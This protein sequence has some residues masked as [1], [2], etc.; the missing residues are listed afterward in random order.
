ML[1]W[2]LHLSLYRPDLLNKM[3]W[4]TGLGDTWK[5][6]THLMQT[7]TESGFKPT[8][9]FLSNDKQVERHFIIYNVSGDESDLKVEYQDVCAFLAMPALSSS[10]HNIISVH[11]I[12][13]TSFQQLMPLA[14]VMKSI[15]GFLALILLLYKLCI[16]KQ[17]QIHHGF[18]ACEQH[19]PS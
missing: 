6:P 17:T 8:E 13:C 11:V 9:N 1:Q 3:L 15:T 19:A 7:R 14:E 12:F 5:A 2:S 10:S 18:W 4:C 16:V